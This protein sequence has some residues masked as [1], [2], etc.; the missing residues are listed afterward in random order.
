MTARSGNNDSVDITAIV[1]RPDSQSAPGFS[2]GAPR[3]GQATG[4]YRIR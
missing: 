3:A 2:A 4:V 1:L